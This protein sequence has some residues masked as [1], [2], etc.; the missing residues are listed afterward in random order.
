MFISHGGQLSSLETIHFGKPIIGVPVF[1]DQYTNIYKAVQNGYAL[2]V[3]FSQNLPKDLK[4][5]INLMLT[6]DR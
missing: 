5:A 3:P 4:P 6:D 1:F 2:K